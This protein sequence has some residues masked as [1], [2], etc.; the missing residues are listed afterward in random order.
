MPAFVTDKSLSMKKKRTPDEGAKR[1]AKRFKSGR[2][3]P[4]YHMHQ[5]SW[6]D[7]DYEGHQDA[8]WE[9]DKAQ[10]WRM[11]AHPAWTHWP[12]NRKPLFHRVPRRIARKGISRTPIQPI[13]ATSSTRQK[14]RGRQR[15]G[16][17]LF[18]RKGQRQG[19]GQGKAKAKE[20][21]AKAK[22]TARGK[23]ASKG[24]EPKSLGRIGRT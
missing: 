1:I 18:F 13:V 9:E 12:F 7:E 17:N 11:M 15:V 2:T 21:R 24:K 14:E 19:K 20:S 6:E 10:Y 5:D 8:D 23:K 3:R 22:D 4:V 16:A